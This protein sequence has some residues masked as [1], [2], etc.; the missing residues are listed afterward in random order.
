MKA[1]SGILGFVLAAMMGGAVS[2]AF[3]QFRGGLPDGGSR[4]SRGGSG[5]SGR[6][7]RPPGEP[8]PAIEEDAVSLT[9]YRL[10]LLHMD[11]KLTPEQEPSWTSFA[12]KASALAVDLS[13]ERGRARA[14]LQMKALQRIDHTLDVARN[15]LTALEDVASAAKAL[16]GRLTPE[17]QSIADARL[18]T[19]VPT[20]YAAGMAGSVPGSA[21]VPGPRD[22]PQQPQ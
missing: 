22:R 21:G 20:I 7:Q 5:A 3:A 17:Q 15:R 11:L 19:A 13:R 2:Q 8:R 10:D 14:I 12:D 9:E 16:Y 4:G 18:A 1:R 6:E